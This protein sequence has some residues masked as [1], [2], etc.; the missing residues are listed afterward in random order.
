MKHKIRFENEKGSVMILAVIFLVLLTILGMSVLTSSRI[1]TQLASNEIR[2]KLAFCAAESAAAYVKC[3]PD[4]YGPDNIT[5][6]IPH[7]FP[8][9]NVPYIGITSGLPTALSINTIQSFNG[10]VEY[11]GPLLPPRGSGYSVGRYR[12]HQ[13]QMVCNG[14]SSK[15]TTKNIVVGFYRIGY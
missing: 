12:A 9:D 13:Y 14:Y 4:L 7:Y 3:R 15:G 5:A 11:D 10:K 6:G 1:D 2:H 8:N